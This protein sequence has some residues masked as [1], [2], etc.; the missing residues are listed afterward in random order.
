MKGPLDTPAGI[1]GKREKCGRVHAYLSVF[2]CLIDGMYIS[3]KRAMGE[4]ERERERERRECLCCNL[5]LYRLYRVQALGGEPYQ[6][7]SR[8]PKA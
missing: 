8:N 4:R 6:Q 7:Q 3:K 1:M 5:I 2:M